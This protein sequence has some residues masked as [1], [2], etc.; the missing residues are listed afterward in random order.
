[1]LDKNSLVSKWGPILDKYDPINIIGEGGYGTV[2]EATDKKLQR[3]VAIKRIDQLFVE[4]NDTKRILREI[5]LLFILENKF[6][7]KLFNIEINKT[8]KDFDTIYLVFEYLPKDLKKIIKSSRQLTLM[9]CK[10]FI[11]HILCGLKYLHSCSVLHRDIKPG[12]IL[13]D[14]EYNIKIC[15][16]GLA[17]CIKKEEEIEERIV[18]NHKKIDKEKL[19]KEGTVLSKYLPDKKGLFQERKENIENSPS[20][21]KKKRPPK[22]KE[23]KEMK[24]QKKAT[25]ILS[26]HVVSRFYR[27]PELILVEANYS[28]AIDIWSVGCIFAELMLTMKENSP[29]VLE[30]TPFF[31]GKCCFPLSPPNSQSIKLN[32]WGFPNEK[33]DQLNVIF[34]IIGSPSDEDIECISDK[35]GILYLKSLKKRQKINFKNKFP[36]SS[37]DALDLLEKMLLFNPQKRIKLNECLNHPFFGDIRDIKKE[38]EANFSLEFEFEKEEILTF[39]RLRELFLKVIN[40]LKMRDN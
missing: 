20:S 2:L 30:R 24:E 36:G 19:A 3:K 17:R 25:Q 40:T 5:T 15:D 33:R 18:D 4:I 34:D 9:E 13:T 6:I 12:N 39:D 11:Y 1:M 27:A 10:L 22:I 16:F 32:E 37:D 23:M 38:K 14:E 31:P 21:S 7:V 8:V 26:Y 28:T 29:N 35:N